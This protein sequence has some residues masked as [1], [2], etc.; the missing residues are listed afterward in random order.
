[1]RARLALG[2]IAAAGLSIA[3]CLADQQADIDY[4][5]SCLKSVPAGQK[6]GLEQFKSLC[7][8]LQ[9]VLDD[10]AVTDR[11]PEHWE[12][13]IRSTGLSDITVLLERYQRESPSSAP[14]TQRVSAIAQALRL[15]D[16]P[17]GWWQRLGEWLRHLLDRRHSEDSGLLNRVLNGIV[18]SLTPRVRRVLFYGSLA[19]VLL[20]VGFIVWRELKAAGIGRRTAKRAKSQSAHLPSGESGELVL[21]TLDDAAPSERPSLLLRL[22]VQALRRSGRLAAER[23]LTHRELI[24]R[25]RF[26]ADDQR[27]RFA[28]ISLWAE[29]QLYGRTAPA[30]QDAVESERV[31]REGREL[32]TQLQSA[33]GASS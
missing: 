22:L 2:F 7:P 32:Y 18:D 12:K 21:A 28:G 20:L 33:G 11:L 3:P 29:R 15:K 31:M 23:T 30:A 26:D 5:K 10:A 1:V 9:H 8:Q 17:R 24:E 6:P 4:L 13:L 14:Q 16:P 27:R 19:L 25:A